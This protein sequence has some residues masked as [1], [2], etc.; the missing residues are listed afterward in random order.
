[1]YHFTPLI[2]IY[3]T[4]ILCLNQIAQPNSIKAWRSL[5]SNTTPPPI[6]AMA[7]S[8][9]DIPNELVR[10][11]YQLSQQRLHLGALR[12]PNCALKCQ[13]DGEAKDSLPTSKGGVEVFKPDA[14]L[15]LLMLHTR[16]LHPEHAEEKKFFFYICQRIIGCDSARQSCLFCIMKLTIQLPFHCE[17]VEEEYFFLF[18]K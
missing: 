1:M 10:S 13:A 8:M 3:T 5:L 9:N 14:D 6:S 7:P 17:N 16:K 2:E 18:C 11:S 4:L 15:L 12:H